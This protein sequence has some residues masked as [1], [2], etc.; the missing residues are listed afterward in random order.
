MSGPGL[1][2]ILHYRSGILTPGLQSER[3]QRV[4]I[5]LVVLVAAAGRDHHKLLP[6]PRIQE[7]HGSSVGAGRQAG[8]PKLAAVVLVECAEAAVIRGA[9]KHQAAGSNE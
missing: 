7:G 6:A 5:G 9:D 2:M 8:H 4:R 3:D 1:M